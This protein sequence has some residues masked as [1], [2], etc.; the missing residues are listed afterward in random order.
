[1][2]VLVTVLVLFFVTLAMAQ[3][4]IFNLGKD[5]KKKVPLEVF[6]L[7][8]AIAVVGTGAAG[9]ALFGARHHFSEAGWLGLVAAVCGI[10]LVGSIIM[11]RRRKVPPEERAEIP[12]EK[13]TSREPDETLSWCPRCQAHTT[14]RKAHCSHCD[15]YMVFVPA[16][17]R[18]ASYGCGG[19]ALVPLLVMTWALLTTFE[20]PTMGLGIAIL[21]LIPFFLIVPFPAFFLYQLRLWKKWAKQKR[22]VDQG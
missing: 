3:I 11:K 2:N 18:K 17:N 7:H 6:K 5:T 20:L 4:V 15:Y 22:A 14:T 10:V 21:M 1:M 16:A 12:E 9:Y 13:I 8:Q 19:C